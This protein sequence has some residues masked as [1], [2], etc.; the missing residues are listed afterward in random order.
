MKLSV[1]LPVNSAPTT[2]A[3]TP[4]TATAIPI[5][6][7][8]SATTSAKFFTTSSLKNSPVV[9]APAAPI[10]PVAVATVSII[11]LPCF[12]QDS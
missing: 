7:A 9:N 5:D 4:A 6:P 10:A 8:T 2:P 12:T 1:T 3:A 11:P